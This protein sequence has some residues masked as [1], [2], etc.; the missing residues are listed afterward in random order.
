MG[1]IF[2]REVPR[3]ALEFTGER[4]TSEVGGQIEFEHL[5]RYFYARQ[6][7]RGRVVL[8]VA[9]GEGYGSAYLAQVAERV[10]GV[11]IDAESIA[12]AQASYGR[13]NLEYVAGSALDIPLPDASVDL[14]VSFETIEHFYEH[15]RF[16]GEVKRVLKPDGLFIVSTPD[17]DIYSAPDDDSNPYHVR[18]LTR[19]EFAE[20]LGGYFPKVGYLL[21]RIMHGSLLAQDGPSAAPA[22]TIEQRG[23]ELFELSP[24]LPRAPYVIAFA[25]AAELPVLGPSFYIGAGFISMQEHVATRDHLTKSLDFA[26]SVVEERGA[27][28]EELELALI[29][30]SARI[31][32]LEEALAQTSVKVGELETLAARG[33]KQAEKLRRKPFSSAAKLIW[34][35]ISRL[36]GRR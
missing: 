14:V 15:E 19:A 28:I 24:G 36:W 25:T 17:R 18:E 32:E 8:D 9:C 20:L 5:H 10:V 26:Q 12:H 7:A 6:L 30:S 21:Q 2:K 16:L 22:L 31:D 27:R 34:A 23:E 33:A 35:G 3:H 1:E 11:D 4:M 13:P 29:S